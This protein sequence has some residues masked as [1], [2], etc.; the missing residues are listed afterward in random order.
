MNKESSTEKKQREP[1]FH[2]I[3][4]SALPLKQSLLIRAVAI[5][6]ALVFAG[7]VTLIL[8]GENPFTAYGTMFRGVFGANTMIS[9]RSTAV[10]LC[11]ALALTPAFKMRFWNT[12]AEGQVLMGVFASAA[13]MFYLQDLP[14][15]LLITCMIVSS[16]VLGSIWSVIPAIFKA[17][18]GTNET[19]FTLMM[20]SV[21]ACIVLFF[22]KQWHHNGKPGAETLD[23]SDKIDSIFG[24]NSWIIIVI[25]LIVTAALYVYLRFSKHG[26]EI[27]V[28]GESENTAKYIGINVKKVII[29]TMAISGLIAGLAGFLIIAPSQ[30]IASTSVGGQGFTAIMVAWLAKFNP[31]VMILSAFLF[32]FVSVGGQEISSTLGYE[33]AYSDILIGILLF[34][35]IGCEFFINYRLIPGNAVKAFFGKIF[36]K[37]K[38]DN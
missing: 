34:F 28:V 27:S 13:C 23:P 2:I 21:A 36:K 20:N 3:K 12:G 19:L 22:M 26:Y 10:L 9:F 1:L 35:I 17:Y 16:L 38:E 32:I 6:L 8:L 18:F 14:T 31:I 29:R 24:A 25:V 11:I 30:S 15:P 4:R 37:K 7:L 5:L 33:A